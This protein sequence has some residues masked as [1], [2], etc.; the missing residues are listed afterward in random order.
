MSQLCCERECSPRLRTLNRYGEQ[1]RSIQEVKPLLMR[2]EL[3]IRRR[4]DDTRPESG[5]WGPFG[6]LQPFGDPFSRLLGPWAQ[7]ARSIADAFTP[8]ADLEETDDA[9]QVE[10]DL[11][12]VKKE[13]VDL[14]ISHRRLKV[15]GQRKEK[16]RV[17]ILRHRER[18]V[19][20]F[21]YEV[22]LPGDIEEDG[23]AATLED[24]VLTV[25]VP[26]AAGD[27]PRRIEVRT[28]TT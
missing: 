6:D 5:S 7:Q 16:E 12:G 8:L 3:P 22:T 28:G 20:H 2:T 21:A 25:R 4:N 11:S 26:K 17:G 27:R 23:V 1:S 15:T 14:E 10:I 18:V 24:G 19:G 9:Y 13:D